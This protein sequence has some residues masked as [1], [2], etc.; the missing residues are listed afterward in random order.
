[1][2][3]VVQVGHFG[4]ILGLWSGSSGFWAILLGL[5]EVVE[6]SWVCGQFQPLMMMFLSL[7]R[8]FRPGLMVLA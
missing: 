2:W 5:D 8:N 1:M 7:L 6:D 4:K 3:L